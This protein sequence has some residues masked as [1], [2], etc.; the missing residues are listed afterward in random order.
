M[1]A[2][3]EIVVINHP[4]RKKLRKLLAAEENTFSMYSSKS[5]VLFLAQDTSWE[6]CSAGGSVFS[7][8]VS[9]IDG[10]QTAFFLMGKAESS[11]KEVD[12]S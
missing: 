4:P 8:L 2:E 3:L 10:I 5:H 1:K 7:L 11:T 9:C 6:N 12:I